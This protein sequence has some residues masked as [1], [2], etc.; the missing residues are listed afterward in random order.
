MFLPNSVCKP[1]VKRILNLQM[2][3]NKIIIH[4]TFCCTFG[5]TAE[6][7][8]FSSF[9]EVKRQKKDYHKCTCKLFIVEES[10]KGFGDT[11]NLVPY[12]GFKHN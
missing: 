1:L 10:T 11:S 4:C 2:N 5:N 7:H 3:M 6:D 12:S 9:R 8:V